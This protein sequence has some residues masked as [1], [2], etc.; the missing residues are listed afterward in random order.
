[1]A[2]WASV[3]GSAFAGFNRSNYSVFDYN[4]GNL[5][6]GLGLSLQY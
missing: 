4:A 6:G 2:E 5:G 1:V 3:F